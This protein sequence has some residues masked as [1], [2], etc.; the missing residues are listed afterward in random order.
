[1][2]KSKLFPVIF[3]ISLCLF[4]IAFSIAL[5]IFIRPF[6]YLQIEPLGLTESG[7][8]KQEI[9]TA[10][11]E[12]LDYLTLP[13]KEFSTGVMKYT[14]EGKDHFKDCKFLFTLNTSVL[15]VSLVIV[16]TLLILKRLKKV[17]LSF[18]HHSAEFYAAL[19]ALILPTF[20]GSIACFNFN[21]AFFLF[22]NILFP[23]KTNWVLKEEV[24]EIIK[25]L[26][27][28]F[29]INCAILIAISI[30]LICTAIFINEFIKAK[31]SER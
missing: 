29:F 19:F 6:Y 14:D 25:I 10:Y 4:I 30:L 9:K 8:T 2:Q 16:I 22:H 11:N 12:V 1:M 27:V 17:S 18:K 20:F 21:A 28:E 15:F 24:D 26:P 31:K 13:N 3:S 5:P 23:N 7:F